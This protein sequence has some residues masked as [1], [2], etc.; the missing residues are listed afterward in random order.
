M[1]LPP[2][3][4]ARVSPP[5]SLAICWLL[6]MHRRRAQ[7][8]FLAALTQLKIWTKLQGLAGQNGHWERNGFLRKMG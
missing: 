3:W 2:V 5:A 6:G 7:K 4:G 1:S 8:E